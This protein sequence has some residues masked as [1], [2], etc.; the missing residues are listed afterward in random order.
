MQLAIEGPELSSVDFNEIMDI[1]VF[2]CIIVN[3]KPTC[4]CR[5]ATVIVYCLSTAVLYTPYVGNYDIIIF[6]FWGGESQGGAPP[7]CM[8]P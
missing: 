7:P 2:C 8:K 4:N 6:K 3:I 5:C 1:F